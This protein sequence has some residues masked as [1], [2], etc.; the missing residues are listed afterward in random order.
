MMND[1]FFS[2]NLKKKAEGSFATPFGI[3]FS[4]GKIRKYSEYY[5]IFTPSV[6][7]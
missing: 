6:F 1:E 2:G 7:M 5:P 4:V 3:S